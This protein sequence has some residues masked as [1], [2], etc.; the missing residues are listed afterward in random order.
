[1]I[2]GVL[3]VVVILAFA[4]QTNR[5]AGTSGAWWAQAFSIVTV[6]FCTLM[7]LLTLYNFRFHDEPIQILCVMGTYTLCSGISSRLGLQPRVSQACILIMQGSLAIALATF[8]HPIVR[9]AAILSVVTAY[10][11]CNSIRIQYAIIEEQVRT[12]RRLR[13]LANH[14]SLTG[15]PNR[16]Y[17]ETELQKACMRQS[18]FSLWMLDLDGFKKVNDTFG[19]AAGD[20]LLKQ[21][22]SRLDRVVRTGDLLARLGGDE[23]V[24]L[25]TESHS[26]ASMKKLAVRINEE[27]SIP[28]MVGNHRIAISVSVGIKLTTVGKTN[29]DQAMQEADCALY[30]AKNTGQGGFEFA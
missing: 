16:H 9:Y 24:I 14:D 3:R 23:F 20:E 2:I 4:M 18:A 11:Y 28:Y 27:L 30:R 13:N 7:G 29:P 15:L 8:P 25:Q 6:L 5:L 12:R 21:V 10:A 17:F 19:H 26:V 22:A 1:M